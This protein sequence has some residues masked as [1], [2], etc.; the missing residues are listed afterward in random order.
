[1]LKRLYL[2]VG[3][4]GFGPRT[5]IP[6]VE[7]G[8]GGSDGNLVEA[9]EF[10]AEEPDLVPWISSGGSV[11]LQL[12]RSD[13]VHAR[14]PHSG[15]RHLVSRRRVITHGASLSPGAPTPL[16]RRLILELVPVIE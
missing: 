14:L 12:G 10:M 13:L 16:M 3:N 6:C 8:K 15:R 9:N 5:G 2:E 7:G 1:L 11:L 4:G